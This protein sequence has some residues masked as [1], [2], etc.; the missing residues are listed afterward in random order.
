[1]E[2]WKP[3]F[4][5]SKN[6]APFPVAVCY[7]Y[8]CVINQNY[9]TQQQ[10]KQQKKMHTNWNPNQI[11]KNSPSF[12]QPSYETSEKKG[13]VFSSPSPDFQGGLAFCLWRR[14]LW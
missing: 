9:P 3:T 4:L 6:M 7:L 10:K 13:T 2:C 1:M 8:Q 5:F 14:Y 12:P 11:S